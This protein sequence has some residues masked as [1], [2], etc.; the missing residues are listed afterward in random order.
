MPSI[1]RCTGGCCRPPH[2]QDEIIIDTS[3]DHVCEY[4][5][6]GFLD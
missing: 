6:A 2:G 4:A 5:T 1:A 3:V